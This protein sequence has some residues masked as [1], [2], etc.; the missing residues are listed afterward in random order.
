MKRPWAWSCVLLGLTLLLGACYPA[1][2]N[3]IKLAVPS[4]VPQAREVSLAGLSLPGPKTC[5]VHAVDLIGAWVA[6]GSTEQSVRLQRCRWPPMSWQLR[7]RR[8]SAVSAGQLVVLGCVVVPD[9]SWAGREHSLRSDGLVELPRDTS[10]IG[11]R[12][13]HREGR[14]Y[15]RR[16]QLAG[17]D[18]V[19]APQPRRDATQRPQGTRPS[20]SG[21]SC[22][23]CG[24]V[25]R[26]AGSQPCF[27]SA[28]RRPA[29]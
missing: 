2:G 26:T 12:L 9:M 10:R 19:R 6:A 18:A 27:G 4:Q 23:D 1:Y 11:P 16:R 22:R 7:R 15:P 20:R 29:L 5:L 3:P 24:L 14:G 17:C 8:A 25:R 21:C 13:G 28:S